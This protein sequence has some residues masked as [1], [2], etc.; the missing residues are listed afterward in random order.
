MV[1]LDPVDEQ[2]EEGRADCWLVAVEQVESLGD[3]ALHDDHEVLLIL[4]IRQQLV[5]VAVDL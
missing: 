1:S 3:Q 5:D 4:R 2:L